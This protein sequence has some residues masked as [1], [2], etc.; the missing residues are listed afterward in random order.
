MKIKYI[1]DLDNIQVKEFL[2]KQGV[3]RNLLKKVRIND[4]AYVNGK[5]VK[6]FLI[7]KKG[8]L[9]EI[10]YS[11]NLNEDFKVNDIPLDVLYE[12]EHILI[13][14]K[15]QDLAIQPSK[16][17]Q[18]D[19]LISS[20][21]KYYLDHNIDSNIHIV[22]RLDFST[23]GIVLIAKNGYIHHLLNDINYDKKYLC[24]VH[25][26]FDLL[27]GCFSDPIRR[28]EDINIKRWV[29]PD[30]KQA[31]TKYKVLGN[32][33]ISLVEATLLTG[34]THQIRVH[35]AYHNHPLVGDKLYGLGDGKLKLHCYYLGFL[36]PIT[37]KRI[38]ICNYPEW[39]NRK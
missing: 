25:N 5:Q 11:E 3:S 4:L 10:D 32:G 36:H 7:L 19:N 31:L 22:T 13:V 12:D 18:E 9:L 39:Y 24:L 27:E 14:N 16:R 20:I 26:R 34:R 35:F 21:K 33:D 17:H 38:E 15:K 28:V 30:G 1:V 23:S 8:D 2:K 6:N 37:N 29:F